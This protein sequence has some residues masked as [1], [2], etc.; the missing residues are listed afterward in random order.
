MQAELE[1]C[2]TTSFF[3]RVLLDKKYA[4]PYRVIDALVGARVLLQCSSSPGCCD[5]HAGLGRHSKWLE[6]ASLC[7]V[8]AWLTSRYLVPGTHVVHC[9]KTCAAP[10]LHARELRP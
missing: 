3:M 5:A 4:L 7:P 1:Y 2:G 10:R 6:Q 9:S 8:L